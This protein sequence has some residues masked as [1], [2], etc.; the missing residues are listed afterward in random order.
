MGQRD[1]V[2]LDE[3]K[4]TNPAMMVSFQ[5]LR[6]SVGR[7]EIEVFGPWHD[8]SERQLPRGIAYA[9]TPSCRLRQFDGAGFGWP[10]YLGGSASALRHY[11]RY[12]P[13]VHTGDD[14][15]SQK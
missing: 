10:G 8:T 5:E 7:R 6:E 11:R 2:G 12:R 3:K 9:G 4:G 13:A 1:L 15:P 14:S